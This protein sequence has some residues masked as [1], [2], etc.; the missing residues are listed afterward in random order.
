[1]RTAS[2]L[3][4]TSSESQP[5][6]G[7]SVDGEMRNSSGLTVNWTSF[8]SLNVIYLQNCVTNSLFWFQNNFKNVSKTDEESV[9]AVNVS[10]KL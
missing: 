1:M 5:A 3:T 7:P 2:V 4:G 6:G 9:S 10:E 8:F